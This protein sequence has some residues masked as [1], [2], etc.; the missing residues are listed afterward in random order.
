MK[1]KDYIFNM[2]NLIV[3]RVR[4]HAPEHAENV[5]LKRLVA[6]GIDLTKPVFFYSRPMSRIMSKC[7]YNA[8]KKVGFN[9][10]FPTYQ[11]H[12]HRLNHIISKDAELKK[13]DINYR[14]KSSF[15]PQRNEKYILINGEKI[16]RKLQNYFADGFVEKDGVNCFARECVLSGRNIFLQFLNTTSQEKKI[17]FEINLP[18]KRGYYSFQKLSHAVKVTRLFSGEREFFNYSSRDNNFTFSCVDGVE[19]CTFASINLSCSLK[20]KPYQ[21][22]HFFYNFGRE[23]FTL[24]SMEEI[25]MFFEQS[26]K[27]AN[28]IFDVKIDSKIKNID[29]KINYILPEKIYRAWLDGQSDID[30]EEEYINLK[31]RFIL[32]V[33]SDYILNETD[34]INSLKIFNGT[35]FRD[36][37][38]IK[39]YD[40]RA[41]EFFGTSNV[42]N[43]SYFRISTRSL[44]GKNTP[45]C[46]V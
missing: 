38:V 16:D 4:F 40:E 11:P 36:V 29:S 18:L 27:K 44:S 31:K 7:F 3:N 2:T 19:N 22:K 28:E 5:D 6:M 39:N 21:R 20:L 8:Q 23:K 24:N 9:L 37:L 14:S 26:Q 1:K 13:L 15:L 42:K 12:S 35:I 45:I 34:K 17:E 43:P 46:Y 33:N 10:V 30:S 41:I 25:E 32:K